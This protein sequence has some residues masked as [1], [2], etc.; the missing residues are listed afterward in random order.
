M[1]AGLP[2]FYKILLIFNQY[3]NQWLAVFYPIV[4]NFMSGATT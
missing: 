2:I 1:Y 3:D 4:F